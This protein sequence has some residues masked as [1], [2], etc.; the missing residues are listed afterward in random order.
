MGRDEEDGDT[1][2]DEMK[3]RED[4]QTKKGQ[5]GVREK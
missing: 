4:G 1:G 5:K 2:W 3:G